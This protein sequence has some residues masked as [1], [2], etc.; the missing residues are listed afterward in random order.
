MD[1]Y[2][3]NID[4]YKC[5]MELYKSGTVFLI[6]FQCSLC[7]NSFCQQTNLERHIRK[8]QES[9][10]NPQEIMTTNISSEEDEEVDLET[11]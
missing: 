10:N 11:V 7:E 3:C 8:H 9:Y 5:K 2:K 1:F 4:F 6:L